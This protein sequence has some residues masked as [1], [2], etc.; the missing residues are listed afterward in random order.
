MRIIRALARL[1]CIIIGAGAGT[2]GTGQPTASTWS[3]YRSGT[4][5]G[6][7]GEQPDGQYVASSNSPEAGGVSRWFGTRRDAENWL[8][9]MTPPATYPD[10]QS[11]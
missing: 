5:V 4:F 6:S 9:G 1:F 7:V 11:W 2:T 3:T 8:G 10:Q